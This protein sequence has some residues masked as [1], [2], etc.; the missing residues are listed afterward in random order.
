MITIDALAL[1]LFAVNGTSKAL[2]Y[3]TSGMTAVFLGT[4]TAMG[5]GVIR[6]MLVNEVPMVVRDPHLYVVPAVLGS[7][8]TVWVWR[9]HTGRLIGDNTEM[10]LD[11]VI[12]LVV[13]VLRICS[14]KFNIRLPGAVQRH[15]VHLPATLLRGERAQTD[16]D[17]QRR[18]A[19]PDSKDAPGPGAVIRRQADRTNARSFQISAYAK[20]KTPAVGP[21]AFAYAN[22]SH[23][24]DLQSEAGFT[25]RSLVLGDDALACSL[26]EL[27]ASDSEGGLSG[28]LVAG[29]DGFAGATDVGLQSGL[30][31][32]VALMRLLVRANALLLRLDVCHYLFS[33][34]SVSIRT[35]K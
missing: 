6:D 10:L 7:I 30:D 11:V 34:R 28:G 19:A 22:E 2:L 31:R 8:F 13:I 4:F 21:R 20:E 25:V 14:V 9:A 3:N 24:V 18:K 1:G 16:T 27:A 29:S 35:Y 23:G 5:G 26:V 17:G 33:K 32:N 15:R 12:V